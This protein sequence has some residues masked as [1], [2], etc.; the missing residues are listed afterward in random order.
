MDP[1]IEQD[2]VYASYTLN[3]ELL[4]IMKCLTVN[5]LDPE[6]AEM[7]VGL[8]VGEGLIF[9]GKNTRFKLERIK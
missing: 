8:L 9:E 7:L 3:N 4:S 2:S 6:S 5:E 1:I